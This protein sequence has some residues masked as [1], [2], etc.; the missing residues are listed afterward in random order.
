MAESLK[1][2]IGDLLPELLANTLIFLSPLQ[3][4]GTITTGAFQTFLNSLDHFLILVQLD[5]HR[6]TS[7]PY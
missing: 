5:C 1:A 2:G 3:P 7:L 6:L 4:A